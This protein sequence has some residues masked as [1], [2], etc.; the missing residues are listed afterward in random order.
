MGVEVPW[1]VS[2]LSSTVTG[3]DDEKGHGA[4]NMRSF[5]SQ[6]PSPRCQRALAHV[7]LNLLLALVLGEAGCYT[8]CPNESEGTFCGRLGKDCDWVTAEN[9]CGEVQTINCYLGKSCSGPTLC[10]GGGVPNVCGKF[11][12]NPQKS[13][14]CLEGF[15]RISSGGYTIG[16]PQQGRCSITSPID[17]F[18]ESFALETQ[19]E[20]S[21]T[22]SFEIAETETTQGQFE[23]VMGYL[24]NVSNDHQPTPK[25][26][27][28][29]ME[30]V[31]WFM[32]AAYANALS[33]QSGYPKCYSCSGDQA[34]VRC[35]PAE[36]YQGSKIYTCRGYR[37]PTEAEWEIA[38]RAGSQTDYYN[39]SNLSTTCQCSLSANNCK[40]LPEARKIAWF[41]QNSHTDDNLNPLPAATV[42]S[43]FRHHPVKTKVRPNAR[44]LYD[45]AGNV[46]EWTHG[47][48]KENPGDDWV[49]DPAGE[50]TGDKMILKGGSYE[51]SAVSIRGATRRIEVPEHNCWAVGFRLARSLGPGPL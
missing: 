20:V 24:P 2:M 3:S 36:E 44:G 19:H 12:P 28:L 38:Y 51:G 11:D 46:W 18:A 26:K 40:D 21:L 37:L 17:V 10:G 14:V 23:E 1:T 45:M 31:T 22:H 16:S 49:V 9:A 48:A 41:N 8:G 6:G 42:Q 30:T 13:A 5:R 7:A 29:P 32:A 50:L 34:L 15:C 33:E 35:A 47:Y 43:P 25:P 4:A 39:G 27:N